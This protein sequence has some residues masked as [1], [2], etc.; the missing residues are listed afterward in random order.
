M[1][2]ISLHVEDEK[3]KKRL[4]LFVSERIDLS[5]SQVQKLIKRGAI[6]RNGDLEKKAGVELKVGDILEI[7]LPGK[8]SL[9][10]PNISVLHETDGFLIVE[11]P[12][13][14][15]VHPKQEEI[16][17]DELKQT[18]TVAAWVATTHPEIVGVGEY[19]NRPGIVHRLDRESSGL[20][21]IAKTQESF[22]HIKQQFKDRKVEKYYVA[23]CHGQI[24][25]EHD[26]IDFLIGRGKDGKMA[27]RPKHEKVTLKNV[28]H[29][30]EGRDA[31][32]EFWVEKVFNHY[33]LI[34]VKLH[35][36]RTHQI[37]VHLF[38]Y[39]HPLAGDSLYINKKIQVNDVSPRLFLHATD[40]SFTDLSG[41]V[42]EFHSDLPEDLSNF[43][44]ILV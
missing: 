3:D 15:V 41:V 11:K 38:A 26:T 5:R 19:V 34:R 17:L 4:D 28:D 44:D 33:S 40:L 36:G 35:T 32:T 14:V 37:R 21:I 10:V 29:L 42:H 25:K 7:S 22:E 39:D 23:L 9:P 31:L 16:S 12:Y 13:D 30:Q 43:L 2:I 20:M 27:A 6:T 24:E 8:I 1:N 18:G